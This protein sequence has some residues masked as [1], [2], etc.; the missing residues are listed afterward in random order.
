MTEE[1][2]RIELL[3]NCI[4]NLKNLSTFYKPAYP[5]WILIQSAWGHLKSVHHL[6][7]ETIFPKSDLGVKTS[8]EVDEDED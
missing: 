2:L 7:T 3:N 8:K 4:K 6:E 1:E 5:A